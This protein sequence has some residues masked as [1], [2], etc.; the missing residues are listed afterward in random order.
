MGEIKQKKNIPAK[1]SILDRAGRAELA[2]NDFRITQTEEKL[3][4]V[5]GEGQATT[6]HRSAGREVRKAIENIG[7]TMP[8]DLPPEPHIKHLLKN[9]KS[10]KNSCSKTRMKTGNEK[11]TRLWLMSSSTF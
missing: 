8:E 11:P 10:A 5:T 4:G 2:A 3:A 1:E 6:I 9:K 7:G